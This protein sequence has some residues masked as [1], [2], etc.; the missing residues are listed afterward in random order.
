[1]FSKD[2]L[3]IDCQLVQPIGYQWSVMFSCIMTRHFSQL[4]GWHAILFSCPEELNGYHQQCNGS[5]DSWLLLLVKILLMTGRPWHDLMTQ[6]I[7]SLLLILSCTYMKET[8]TPQPTPRPQ[9]RPSP[10]PPPTATVASVGLCLSIGLDRPPASL[11]RAILQLLCI[12]FKPKKLCVF[13]I[14]T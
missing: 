3:D 11:P 7:H 6:V 1:M 14:C 5:Q 2:L 4:K 13:Q 9:R 8:P 12:K 10:R